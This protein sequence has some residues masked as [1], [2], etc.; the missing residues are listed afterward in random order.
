MT[1]NVLLTLTLLAAPTICIG[2]EIFAVTPSGATEMIFPSKPPAVVSQISNKCMD[3]QWKVASTSSNEVICE[4]PLSMGQS[5]MGQMLLGNSYS[6]PPR[7]FFRFNV[8]ETAGT[9]RVQA[10]GWMETQ[11]AFGQ[12]KRVD[13]SGAEFHN[14]VMGFLSSAG[15][16]FP[17]GTRFPNHV[18]MGF[19]A[20]NIQQGKYGA[21][22][23]K[24]VMANTPA[25]RAGLQ[26]GDVVER[27][28]DRRFKNDEEYLEAIAKAA[29]SA[30]YKIGASRNGESISLTLDREFR[31]P[32][33]EAVVAQ[34]S[35]NTD[36]VQPM[37][38]SVADELAKL[39]KLK[40]QGVLTQA[41]FDAQ[42]AKLL[43]L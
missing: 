10:S 23:V 18:V 13:F 26:I 3:T 24:E 25:E 5:I 15:G 22:R 17:I 28:A 39:L 32:F 9:S 37:S 31:P 6:T 7:R 34:P 14:S 19:N 38:A 29:K 36:S 20:E 4:A 12:V 2:G 8:V 43:A 40:E 33:A 30:T 42:K 16:K 41:E 35:A 21:L 27:I 11:M 1:R